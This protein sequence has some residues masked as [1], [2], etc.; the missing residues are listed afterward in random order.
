VAGAVKA[1]GGDP[2]RIDED[3]WRGGK[4]LGYCEVHIEQG[5]VLEA[6]GLPV[7]VVSAISGQDRFTL[8]FKGEAGHAGT[9]PMNRRRDALVAASV[10]VQAVE[11]YAG[12][13]DGLVATVGQLS[14]QP[15]AANVVPG[16]V[17]LSLDVRHAENAARLTA[18]RSLLDIAA[19]IAN[20]RNISLTTRRISEDAAV[21]CSPLLVSTLSEAVRD[22]GHPVLQLASGAGHDAVAMSA[23]TDVGMLF[24]RCKGGISHNPAESVMTGDVTVAID[25]LSR[26]IEL[27][28][29]A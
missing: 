1:F 27:L 24:V 12:G 28:A 7:G 22:S 5:P 29:E 16:E 2:A 17:T 23:I 21:A 9:V 14:V 8:V 18:S 26:F 4:L 25:V 15:G 10:F 20:S 6:Q 19:T 11:G 13:F 3:K